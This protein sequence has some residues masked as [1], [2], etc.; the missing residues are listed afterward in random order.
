MESTPYGKAIEET[1]SELSR[2]ETAPRNA[3]GGWSWSAGLSLV[4]LLAAVGCMVFLSR[5]L[6]RLP[7][8]VGGRGREMAILDR[9]PLTRQSSLLIVRLRGR[10]YWLAE[11][12]HGVELLTE[13]PAAVVGTDNKNARPREAEEPANGARQGH[14]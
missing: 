12:P 3:D 13:L 6:R 8:A 2:T 11:H 10:D 1:V 4:A 9:V 14:A 5:W 7:F